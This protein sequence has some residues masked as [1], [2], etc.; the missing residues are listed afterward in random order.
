MSDIEKNPIETMIDN[1]MNSEFNTAGDIFNDLLNTKVQD[2]VDQ[3]KIALAGQ[4]FNSSV[5]D[6]QLDLDFDDEDITDEDLEAAANDLL[7]DE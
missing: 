7:D 2:A 4:I 3:E 6:E 5:D 1:I